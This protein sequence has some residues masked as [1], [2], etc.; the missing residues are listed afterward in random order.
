M[1]MKIQTSEDFTD[2]Y[3]L[4]NLGLMKDG[5]PNDF[6]LE[7]WNKTIRKYAANRCPHHITNIGGIE[8]GF[9]ETI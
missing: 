8:D 4:F 3:N 7:R 1:E 6:H 2:F 5:Y 9:T